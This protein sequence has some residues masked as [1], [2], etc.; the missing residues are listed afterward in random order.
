M[1]LR[2]LLAAL[3]YGLVILSP[4]RTQA[5]ADSL[6]AV[7]AS[8]EA[9]LAYADSTG[10]LIASFEA[11][12]HLAELARS[13]QAFT[14]LK[15]A[16]TLADSLRR[17]DLGVMARRMLAKRHAAAGQYALAFA[18]SQ[19]ADSLDH[20]RELDEAAEVAARHA[21]ERQQLEVAADSLLQTGLQR[22]RTMAQAIVEL[23]TKADRWMLIALAVLLL[24]LLLVVWLLYRAGRMSTRLQGTIENLRKDVGDRKVRPVPPPVDEEPTA[25][26]VP[27]TVVDE[28]MKPV[29][30]GLFRKAAPERLQTLRDARQRQDIEKTLRVVASVK[31]QLLAFDAERFGPLIARLKAPGAASDA[32]QWSADLDALEKGIEEWSARQ[33]DW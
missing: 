26:Q 33:K 31:P 6:R 3:L 29:V 8:Q 13:A 11:R 7:I 19:G 22:E 25:V 10:N 4:L 28:A 1:H 21:A 20:L 2:L 27:P 30:E 18:A 16:C 12:L 5:Q 9:A 24:A 14:L 15:E 23:Q 32:L 17:P